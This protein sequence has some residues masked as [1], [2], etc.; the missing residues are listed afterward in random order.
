MAGDRDKAL[1][2]GMNDHIAKPINVNDMFTKMAKWITPSTPVVEVAPVSRD[3]DDSG[4][5]VIPALDGID[6][7]AGLRTTQDNRAFYLRLLRMFRDE[8]RDFV[9]RFTASERAGDCA[10]M[11]RAAHTLKGLAG[12]IGAHAVRE[13]AGALERACQ[14]QQAGSRVQE[15]LDLVDD[16]LSSVLQALDGLGEGRAS[17]A[18]ASDTTPAELQPMFERLRVRLAEFDAEAL[19]VVNELGARLGGTRHEAAVSHLQQLVGDFDFEDAQTAMD[20]LAAEL[21]V[22]AG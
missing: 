15:Q 4:E 12:N 20:Q 7:A 22:R 5:V 10:A 1:D 14:E 13:A 17:W 6:V 21:G 16:A 11:T 8:Q 18:A 9:A 2:A 19:E 3:A